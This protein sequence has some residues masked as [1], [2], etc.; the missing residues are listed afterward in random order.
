MRTRLLLLAVLV[1]APAHAITPGEIDRAAAGAHNGL[2]TVIKKLAGKKL[3]GRDN[4]TPGSLAAQTYLIRKLRRLGRGLAGGGSDDASFKQP[5][6]H[7]GQ[8]GTNLLAVMRGADLANEYVMI[9]AHYDH[10]DSRS[11]STGGCL[12]DGTPGGAEICNGAA[13]NA[14][15]VAATLAIAKVL[16][17]I[18]PPRR[19]VIL[20]FWDAEEDALNG[21]AYYAANPLVP[22]AAV[23]AYINFDIQ[24][25]NLLPSIK[26][27]SFAVGAET[28]GPGFEAVVADAVAA[29]GLDTTLLSYIFGQLRSDYVNLV[30]AGIPT[31]FF[32]DANNGC[33]H[34]VD[35]DVEFLD[36]KKL[37]R[38]THIAFRTAAALT[39]TSTPPPFVAPNPA[40]ATFTDLER[41]A[42]IVRSARRDVGL[43]QPADQALAMDVDATLQQLVADGP[44]AF[45]AADVGTL[46]QAAIDTVNALRRV[47]C[48]KF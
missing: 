15:G 44:A 42:A 16:K 20:G 5:F 35:D 30:G 19:S 11:D 39:E 8:S 38:Q 24:G 40:L 18:G 10:L 14:S 9:G 25:A 1:A 46:L 29:E 17:K 22:N 26:T 31:V 6:T 45:D 27:V 36:F 37:R 41:V 23:K 43:F 28:G 4:A 47:P 7:L 32:T 2:R 3:A 12:A 21:S 34:T 33:Y 13:D 48:Q